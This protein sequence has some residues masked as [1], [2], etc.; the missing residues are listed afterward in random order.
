[1]THRKLML[2]AAVAIA[3]VLSTGCAETRY[4]KTRKAVF[5]YEEVE[6]FGHISEEARPLYVADHEA[7]AET[8]FSKADDGAGYVATFRAAKAAGN[9]GEAIRTVLAALKERR[10]G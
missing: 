3:L 1:M 5:A 4:H 9:L 10:D 7:R 2:I 8:V 6:G